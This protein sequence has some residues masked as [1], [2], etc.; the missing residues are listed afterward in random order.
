MNYYNEN[1][2]FAAA[3]LR[4]LIADKLIPNGVVDDRSITEV[5]PADLAGFRQCHFFA[6]C[7]GWP[8]AIG[9]ACVSPD[10]ELWTGSAPCQPYSCAG[11]GEGNAD[12]RNLWPQF[13]AL[14]QAC[15]PPLCMGE[16]VP[17]AIRHGWLDRVFDD[18]EGEAYTC[19]AIDLPA[20]SAGSPTIRQRLF[21]LADA[22][23]DRAPSEVRSRQPDTVRSGDADGLALTDGW[24]QRRG[25]QRLHADGRDGDGPA[26]VEE[27]T[28]IEGPCTYCGDP[29]HWRPDC[30]VIRLE[31]AES[32]GRNARRPE[33][34]RGIV[35]SGRGVSRL[36]DTHGGACNQGDVGDRQQQHNAST[37]WSDFDILPCSDGSAR[38]VESGSFPLAHGIPRDTRAIVARLCEL[39]IDPKAAK[40]IIADARRNRVGRLRGYGNAIVP[41]V[42]AE[43]VA[44]YL[45][46]NRELGKE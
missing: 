38:R 45:D 19:W 26:R 30:P 17:D 13:F 37:A 7:A 44:S 8:I 2:K 28:A 39:G 16:Q 4:N 3:W 6:G 14:I 35:A 32:D 18:L 27:C 41:Q 46:I 5:T 43:F 42:A 22:E 23:N 25:Q 40:R 20:C 10:V 1:D 11:K 36:G 29:N 33:P 21:W 24:S 31:R 12:P 34:S 15:R 9:L